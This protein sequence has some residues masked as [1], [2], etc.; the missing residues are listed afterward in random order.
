MHDSWHD[1][2]AGLVF[3]SS[4]SVL[5]TAGG[6]RVR[7]TPL[8]VT[9]HTV[10]AEAAPGALAAGDALQGRIRSPKD[11]S[12]WLVPV[13][14][15]GVH[16]RSGLP[17]RV[18]AQVGEP[19]AD[20]S[21]RERERATVDLAVELIPQDGSETEAGRLV[22]VSAH[23]FGL[24]VPAGATVG[25]G[26]RLRVVVEGRLDVLVEVRTIRPRA[27]E[28]RVGTRFVALSSQ[29]RR[30]IEQRLTGDGDRRRFAS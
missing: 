20:P 4:P 24:I 8:E 30:E 6:G 25:C 14:V 12:R 11:G 21:R 13:V 3:R 18:T 23:G 17:D 26:D 2:A 16:P 5:E 22:D 9:G 29:E 19:V 15:S 1:L 27:D 7:L 28:I 10:V